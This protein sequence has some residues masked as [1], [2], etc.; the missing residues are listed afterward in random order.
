MKIC[1]IKADEGWYFYRGTELPVASLM[2]LA[3]WTKVGNSTVHGTGG[4]G[5]YQVESSIEDIEVNV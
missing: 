3:L 5:F 4:W 2:G 1:E